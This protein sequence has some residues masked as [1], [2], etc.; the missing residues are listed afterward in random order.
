M[1]WEYRILIAVLCGF[2]LFSG[3][4]NTGGKANSPLLEED[5]R[6]S[7]DRFAEWSEGIVSAPRKDALPSIDSLFERLRQDTVAYYIYSD[8]M[9]S[10][11]YLVQSP[12]RQ[13]DIFA[14]AA[15][16]IITD[17]VMTPDETSRFAQLLD[18]A[19]VNREG[20]TAVIPAPVAPGQ[21]TLV[22]VLDLGCPT[23]REALEKLSNA[24]QWKD[25]RKIAIGLGRGS[26]PDA[27]GWE[28]HRPENGHAV[29]DIHQTP[30]YYVVSPDGKVEK[31]YTLAL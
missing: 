9:V 22:L 18:W 25:T 11:F 15:Q 27:P 2:C 4:R 29:F 31:S 10:A 21:R 14:Y 13:P 8:W 16:K 17:G 30:V 3:C 26:L 23:C 12:C 6:V 5:I 1:R 20:E 24:P 19:L 28:I 7:E